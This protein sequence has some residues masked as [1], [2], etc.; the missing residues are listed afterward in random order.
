MPLLHQAP[1]LHVSSN[2][3]WG[4]WQSTTQTSQ[5]QHVVWN[6]IIALEQNARGSDVVNILPLFMP[7]GRK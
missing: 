5:E 4:R 1:E 6:L 3:F 2:L 7:A